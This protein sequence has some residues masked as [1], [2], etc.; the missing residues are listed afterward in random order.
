MKGAAKRDGAARGAGWF[1]C[2]ETTLEGREMV[3]GLIGG[4][5]LLA[6]DEGNADI[7]GRDGGDVSLAV[8]APV[9]FDEVTPGCYGVVL[10]KTDASGPDDARGETG[11]GGDAGAG[12]RRHR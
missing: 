1:C 3:E 4:A 8:V 12:G 7:S 9:D 5:H 6:G 10:A 11:Q 2:D